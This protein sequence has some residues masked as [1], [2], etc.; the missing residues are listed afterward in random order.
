MSGSNC[1]VNSTLYG[2]NTL[3][4]KAIFKIQHMDNEKRVQYKITS[5]YT[6]TGHGSEPSSSKWFICPYVLFEVPL[7]V[8]SLS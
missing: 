5:P 1:K 7:K 6:S 3:R 2:E 8:P 4:L